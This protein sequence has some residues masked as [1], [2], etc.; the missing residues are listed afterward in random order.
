MS[1][2]V[3]SPDGSFQ[4]R[5][6]VPGSYHLVASWYEDDTDYVGVTPIEVGP[7]GVEGASV[8]IEAGIEVEGRVRIDRPR[9]AQ[10]PGEAASLSSGS[11]ARS[12]APDLADLE[13]GLDPKE[14]LPVGGR[15]R[16]TRV[17]E[18]MSFTLRNV[19]QGEYWVAIGGAPPDYFMKAARL[20]GEDLLE[21]GLEI[22]GGRLPGP[23][24]IT[25]S[26]N[27]ARVEG[28]VLTEDQQPFAGAQVTLVPAPRRR[29]R[30]EYYKS[31]TT[32]QYGRFTLRGI[33]PGEY[34]L[35]A[36]E[37]IERGAQR[38][39]EFLKPFED[40]GHEI[41][42]REGEYA[43]AELKLIRTSEARPR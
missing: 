20:G 11:P 24:E 21:K 39:A 41:R 29:E 35:F 22:A 25:L 33:P 18:D 30:S 40:R 5:G 2:P 36:W 23:L 43:S 8:T 28:V 13:V 17:K 15:F 34:K 42:L 6:V 32:D 31:T 7:A 10:A 3:T 37:E 12:E 27:G 38:D 16:N 4:I 1:A 26:P 9:R 19:S 14:F